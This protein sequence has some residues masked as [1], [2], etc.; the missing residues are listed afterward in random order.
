MI[1]IPFGITGSFVLREKKISIN[2]NKA[3]TQF[4]LHYNCDNSDLF[5]NGNK[6]LKQI[7]KMSTFQINFV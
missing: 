6:S 1:G 5:V 7:M 2:F 4:S 3:K